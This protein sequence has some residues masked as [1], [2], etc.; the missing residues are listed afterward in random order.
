MVA[1][2]AIEQNAF[3]F[4]YYLWQGVRSINEYGFTDVSFSIK[5][6]YITAYVIAEPRISLNMP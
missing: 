5:H 6:F 3:S 1:K 2:F 4:V